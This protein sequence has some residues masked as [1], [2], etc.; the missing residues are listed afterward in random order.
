MAST[1]A[2]FTLFVFRD[3]FDPSNE[4]VTLRERTVMNKTVATAFG[5][6]GIAMLVYIAYKVGAIDKVGERLERNQYTIYDKIR[7]FKNE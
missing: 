3:I 1:D 7:N 4:D 2:F 6:F 5:A